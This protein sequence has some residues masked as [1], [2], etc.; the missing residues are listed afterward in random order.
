MA[1]PNQMITLC[2]DQGRL[3]SLTITDRQRSNFSMVLTQLLLLSEV[4]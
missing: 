3:N 1:R 2:M 4:L